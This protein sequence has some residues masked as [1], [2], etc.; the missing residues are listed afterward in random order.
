MMEMKENLVRTWPVKST[1]N[2]NLQKN[3]LKFQPLLKQCQKLSENKSKTSRRSL[4]FKN[5]ITAPKTFH[6]PPLYHIKKSNNKTKSNLNRSSHES[7]VNHGEINSAPFTKNL[8][9]MYS[10]SL[11][12]AI[13]SASEDLITC[14]VK[15]SVFSPSARSYDL[16]N[17]K[18]KSPLVKELNKILGDAKTAAMFK[19]LD[20]CRGSLESESFKG[21]II[22]IEECYGVRCATVINEAGNK[23][24]IPERCFANVG[25]HKRELS[26]GSLVEGFLDQNEF[27]VYEVNKVFVS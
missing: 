16:I 7:S 8:K 5:S 3:R 4:S 9:E 13:D 18:T 26:I 21:K 19:S 24:L 10:N 22:H 20:R 1:E 11:G 17:T 14:Q 12:K 6:Y 15:P 23:K 27:F 2:R 25:L